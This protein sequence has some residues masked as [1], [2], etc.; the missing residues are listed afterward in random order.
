VCM[1]HRTLFAHADLVDFGRMMPVNAV[2]FIW[3]FHNFSYAFKI[4]KMFWIWN[5]SFNYLDDLFTI[6]HSF[7]IF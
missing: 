4:R 5:T 7:F 3:K 6:E 1:Y 2:F